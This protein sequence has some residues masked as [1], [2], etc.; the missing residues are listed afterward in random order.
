MDKFIPDNDLNTD[1]SWLEYAMMK[2]QDEEDKFF[3]EIPL[4]QNSQFK[5]IN[6]DHLLEK[7]KTDKDIER[8]LRKLL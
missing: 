1:N 3:E 8:N 4:K 7:M 6:L 2:Y 5:W